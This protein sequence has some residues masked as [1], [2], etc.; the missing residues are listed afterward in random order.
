MGDFNH[1]H[2]LKNMMKRDKNGKFRA[3]IELPLGKVYEF[4][5]LLDFD[6]WENEWGADGLVKTPF[7]GVY[8]SAINCFDGEILA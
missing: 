5:Y 8:N 4:R 1:W 6:R 3:T 7:E 2:P